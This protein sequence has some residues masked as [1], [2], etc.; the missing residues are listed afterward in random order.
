[1]KQRRLHRFGPK[2]SAAWVAR[3][4]PS[5]IPAERLR[6]G[7]VYRGY[8]A[9]SDGLHHWRNGAATQGHAITGD[10]VEIADGVSLYAG[11]GDLRTSQVVAMPFSDWGVEPI[12]KRTPQ[13]RTLSLATRLAYHFDKFGLSKSLVDELQK[14]AWKAGN[15]LTSEECQ[16]LATRLLTEADQRWE[17]EVGKHVTRASRNID[18]GYELIE[19]EKPHPGRRIFTPGRGHQP[20]G[21]VIKEG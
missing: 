20:A 2:V 19:P 5:F 16:A 7:D 4:Q 10:T 18:P 3:H 12:R 8:E 15:P 1:M 21:P 11:G 17:D 9:G 13:E 6:P 14:V